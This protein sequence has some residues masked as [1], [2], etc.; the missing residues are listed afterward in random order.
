MAILHACATVQSLHTADDDDEDFVPEPRAAGS[1]KR[2]KAAAKDPQLSTAAAQQQDDGSKQPRQS[3]R[4]QAAG[5]VGGGADAIAGTATDF[6][7]PL[8]QRKQKKVLSHCNCGL[9]RLERHHA[10]YSECTSIG[11]PTGSRQGGS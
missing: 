5:K 1:R 11:P 7:L 9:D 8:A 6:F 3:T 4:R 10:M 2:R